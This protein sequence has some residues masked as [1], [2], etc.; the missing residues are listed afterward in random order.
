V[1]AGLIATAVGCE[2]VIADPHADGSLHT[3][4]LLGGGALLYVAT[5]T[6]YLHVTTHQRL[7]RRWIGCAALAAIIPTAALLPDLATLVAVTTILITLASAAP[8]RRY[9]TW[10]HEP[11]K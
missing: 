7:Q 1:L 3:G 9:T 5:Q 2:T 11:T 10:E 8:R 4:F 6:W